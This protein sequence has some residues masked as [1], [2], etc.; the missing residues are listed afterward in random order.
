MT[1][2]FPRKA[3]K[4]AKKYAACLISARGKRYVYYYQSPIPGFR[5][6]WYES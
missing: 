5:H 3:K 4:F 1:K 6:R 2:R